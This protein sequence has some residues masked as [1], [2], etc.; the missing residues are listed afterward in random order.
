[1][2][3]SFCL[4][5]LISL[6]LVGCTPPVGKTEGGADWN[7]EL[8]I[9]VGPLLGIDRSAAGLRFSEKE[10]SS[11]TLY[12][13]V[14]SG[15]EPQG[16]GDDT[17]YESLACVMV[18]EGKPDEAISSWQE[19]AGAY[20]DMEALT[21]ETADGQSFTLFSLRPRQTSPYPCGVLALATHGDFAIS[22]E[23]TCLE[24]DEEKAKTQMLRFLSAFHYRDLS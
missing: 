18:Q 24:D 17:V 22:V 15:G 16:E 14:W 5:L 8:W 6:V 10:K 19:A 20:Y 2:R 7:S 13:G 1:M 23:L 12:Y 11:S 21:P 4:F 9:S 3:R